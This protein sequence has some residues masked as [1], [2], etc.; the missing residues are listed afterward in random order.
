MKEMID[1]LIL[2]VVEDDYYA[3]WE[4]FSV[5]KKKIMNTTQKSLIDILY[6]SLNYLFLNY[7]YT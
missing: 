7:F 3:I 1:C 2:N 5:L 4:I 6:N